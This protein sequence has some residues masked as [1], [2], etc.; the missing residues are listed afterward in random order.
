MVDSGKRLPGAKI[1]RGLVHD[2][3]TAELPDQRLWILYPLV[4]VAVVALIIFNAV[5]SE[6]SRCHYYDSAIH[7]NNNCNNYTQDGQNPDD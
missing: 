4:L 6:F 7:S 1:L 2:V 5:N 3:R